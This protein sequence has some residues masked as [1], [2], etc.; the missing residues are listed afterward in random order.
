MV[1]FIW[2]IV[3]IILG[4]ILGLFLAIFLFHYDYDSKV[5]ELKGGI[6]IKGICVREDNFIELR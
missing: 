4:T 3:C 1:E 2:N 6:Y 5:C